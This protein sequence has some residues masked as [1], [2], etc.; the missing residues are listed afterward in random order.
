M[1]KG[2]ENLMIDMLDSKQR[3]EF[4]RLIKL[5]DAVFVAGSKRSYRF[6]KK[7]QGHIEASRNYTIPIKNYSVSYF[8]NTETQIKGG[9]TSLR[10]KDIYFLPD[11]T[12]RANDWF[13]EIEL[14]SDSLWRSSINSLTLLL[15]DVCYD[16]QDTKEEPHVPISARVMADKITKIASPNG[17]V[18][19]DPHFRQFDALFD[20][21][22][23][24]CVLES[25]P[26]VVRHIRKTGSVPLENL[27]LVSTDIGDVRRTL[28][29]KQGLGITTKMGL[30]YK[31]KELTGERKIINTEFIGDVEGKDVLLVD[32]MIRSGKTNSNAVNLV[33]QYGA[34]RVWTYAAHPWFTDSRK[35]RQLIESCDGVL[36]S[37]SHLHTYLKG[38]ELV[39]LSWIFAEA[40]YRIQTDESVSSLFRLENNK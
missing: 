14:V 37:N 39:D 25:W 28:K 27:V 8:G 38:V 15:T 19:I 26:A 33:K 11:I 35:K 16:T 34:E 21:K 17:I 22:T 40:A 13:A 3:K 5:D 7:M 2:D 29:Q 30:I 20:K 32:D 18:T 12:R 1:E 9:E 4:K 24:V 23:Q 6:M 10:G 36:A 31:E